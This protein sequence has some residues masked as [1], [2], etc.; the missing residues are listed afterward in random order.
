MYTPQETD[1]CLYGRLQ[2][3]V[4]IWQIMSPDSTILLLYNNF[5]HRVRYFNCMHSNAHVRLRQQLTLTVDIERVKT[6]KYLN[7]IV[8]TLVPA[9]T[10]T[11]SFHIKSNFQN[12]E[13]A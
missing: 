8:Y 3:R 12:S 11:Q 9:G 7:I 2:H 4:G 6:P 10:I 1:M 13:Q 5:F